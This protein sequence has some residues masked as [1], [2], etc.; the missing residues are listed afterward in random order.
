MSKTVVINSSQHFNTV[1]SSSRIVVTD[2]YADWCGPCKA[3]APVYEQLSSQLSRPQ[4]VT[5]TKVD[6]D[7][8]RDIATKYSIRSIPTF[9][10][11]KNSSPVTTVQGANQAALV[12]AI[13]KLAAEAD[14]DG[15]SASG[16]FG[17]AG[18]SW[19]GGPL[20]KGYEN[21]T[22][23]VDVRNLELLNADSEF[24][25]VRTLFEGKKPSSL[26]SD[27]KARTKASG[28]KD[29]VVTD[30]DEQLMLFIPFQSTLKIHTLLITSLPGTSG[31]EADEDEVP[32]RPKTIKL[33]ANRSQT[34]GFEEAEDIPPTQVITLSERDWDSK[35]GTAK[36]ELRFV[37][38]QN[39]SSLVMFVVDGD[40]DG[41]K[42]RIDRIRILGEKGEKREGKI[43]KMGQDAD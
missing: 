27:G 29:Y 43:E 3:M 37:K 34:L 32:M 33:Y 20:P 41:E 14:S 18:D 13:K 28:E 26:G 16:G 12:D 10:I 15:A 31:E 38:F 22:D 40:G 42:V 6:I 17:N 9:M 30:T 35:T 5:F 23:A 21:A 4:K 25:G 36:V 8:Q 39:V 24:A 11:F 2:F 7:N 19:L 1:L